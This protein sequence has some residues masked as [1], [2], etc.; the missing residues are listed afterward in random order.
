MKRLA[1]RASSPSAA[2]SFLLSGRRTLFLLTISTTFSLT[3]CIFDSPG[4]NFY[5]TLWVSEEQPFSDDSESVAEWIGTAGGGSGTSGATS[6]DGDDNAAR[7]QGDILNG[8]I[9]IEFLCG[10]N[11]SV[12]AAGAVGSFGTYEPHGSTAYFANLRLTYYDGN[13][14]IAIILEEAHRTDDILLISWH[15]EGTGTSYTTGLSR[16]SSYDQP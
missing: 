15:Y 11:I 1:S 10:G 7:T 16:R 6:G 14:P 9:T 2:I 8:K 4:D 12:R 13:I 5:R 3:S